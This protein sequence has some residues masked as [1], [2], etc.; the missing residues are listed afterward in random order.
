MRLSLTSREVIGLIIGLLNQDGEDKTDG[1]VLD[2]IW[3]TL[4]Y[5]GYDPEMS[6][7]KQRG[8]RYRSLDE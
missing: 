2:E 3:L 5:N 1:E 4:E 7:A 8:E 6:I